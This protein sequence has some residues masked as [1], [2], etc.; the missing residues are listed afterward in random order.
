MICGRAA[1]VASWALRTRRC[2]K[3]QPALAKAKI[4]LGRALSAVRSPSIHQCLAL[5]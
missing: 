3:L 4:F 2:K 5:C 1:L